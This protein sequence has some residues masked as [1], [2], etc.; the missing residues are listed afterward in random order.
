MKFSWVSR[1]W[2]EFRIGYSTYLVFLFGFSNFLLLLYNFFP[3]VKDSLNFE[4]FGIIAFVLIVP[5]AVLFGRF[6]NKKQFGTE[7]EIVAKHTFYKD[8]MQPESKEVFTTNYN[9]FSIDYSRWSLEMTKW[10]LGITEKQ[11]EIMNFLIKKDAPELVIAEKER[12]DEFRKNIGD[13]NA[14]LLEWRKK[15]ENFANGAEASKLV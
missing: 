8:K 3:K 6:H 11:I 9:I 4:I 14:V 15:Y 7:S 1:R 2:F 13:W 10:Q 12:L 5:V